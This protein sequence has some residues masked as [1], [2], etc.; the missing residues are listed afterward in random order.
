MLSLILIYITNITE[1]TFYH[2]KNV[3]EVRAFLS[4]SM[5]SLP[6]DPT[7]VTLHFLVFQRKI[8]WQN[9]AAR[10]L[11]RTRENV[12]ITPILK[13]LH[14]P[15]VCSRT[16]FKILLLVYKALK[17]LTLSYLSDLLLWTLW[18]P[19]EPSGPGPWNSLHEDRGATEWG[20]IYL[21]YIY[22]FLFSLAFNSVFTYFYF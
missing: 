2:L 6:A 18:N 17:G 5:P 4:Q 3:V 1:T 10:V 9:P 22:T 13:P 19:R 11:T 21:Y 8:L 14:W 20:D 12:H 15:A 7:A 16:D